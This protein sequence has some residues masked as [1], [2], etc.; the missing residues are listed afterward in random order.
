MDVGV[1]FILSLLRR[2]SR[3]TQEFPQR[4]DAKQY[5]MIQCDVSDDYFSAENVANEA[6][7]TST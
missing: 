7:L 2:V 3:L 1:S 6:R 4:C 5:S